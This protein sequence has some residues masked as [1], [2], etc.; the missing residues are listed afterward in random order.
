MNKEGGSEGR[1]KAEEGNEKGQAKIMKSE[2]IKSIVKER[3]G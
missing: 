2:R 3:E 1:E